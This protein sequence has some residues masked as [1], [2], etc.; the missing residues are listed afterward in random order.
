MA[1]SSS[2]TSR[3]RRVRRHHHI[4]HRLVGTAQRPRLNVF[5]SSVNIYAQVIDDARGHT[6]AHA[7]TLDGTICGDTHLKKIEQAE[8]V[9]RLVA[10][11]ARAAGVDR[12]VFDRGGYLYHGRVKALA[13]GARAGGLDF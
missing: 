3:N 9:G 7:S 1:T 10:E 2:K 12:I 13:D 5:R 4:R 6:L 8:A 11:R